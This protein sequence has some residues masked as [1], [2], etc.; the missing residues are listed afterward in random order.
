M[1]RP[2]VE[3]NSYIR[4]GLIMGTDICEGSTLTYYVH[5][6]NTWVKIPKS[7]I[8]IATGSKSIEVVKPDFLFSEV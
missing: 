7:T 1:P 3:L 5:L 6:M 4:G 2:L 8:S